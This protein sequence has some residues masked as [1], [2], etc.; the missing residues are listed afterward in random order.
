M[1]ELRPI[2]TEFEMSYP[3]M[4]TSTYDRG[5]TIK[6]RIVAHKKVLGGEI[7]EIIEPLEIKEK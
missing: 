5:R 7:V 6:N 4:E 2:G 1:S 3:P